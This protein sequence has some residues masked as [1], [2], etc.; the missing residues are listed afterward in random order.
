MI[1]TIIHL[2]LLLTMPPLL[3]GV[4]NKTKAF[5]A[6]RKGPPPMKGGKPVAG[7]KSPPMQE[8]GGKDGGYSF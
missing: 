4:I 5:V 3:L 8:A 6:G 1:N 2:V 7:A